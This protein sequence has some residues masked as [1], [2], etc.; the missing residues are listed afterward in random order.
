MPL[1]ATERDPLRHRPARERSSALEPEVVVEPAG[2]VA[3]DDEAGALAFLCAT[4]WLRRLP[5]APLAA[6]LVEAHLWIVAIDATLSSPTA[7]R[8]GVFPA[9]LDFRCRG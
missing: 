9:Q 1:A 7:R 5:A 4:E 8:F 2:V 6:V 3:L